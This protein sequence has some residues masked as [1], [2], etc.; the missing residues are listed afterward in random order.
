M[1]PITPVKNILGAI[2]QS[3]VLGRLFQTGS[4]VFVLF[5]TL[6]SAKTNTEYD[7]ILNTFDDSIHF[8]PAPPPGYI[9][10]IADGTY[11]PSVMG[12]KFEFGPNSIASPYFG[13]GSLGVA[14]FVNPDPLH[15]GLYLGVTVM[16]DTTA[17]SITI[18]TG[19]S[20]PKRR[21]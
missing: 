4:T 11:G 19:L 14:N 21:H 16:S 6:M 20:A 10:T 5:V 12:T 2:A 15:S 17:N 1:L 8:Y 9:A 18:W 13:G 7:L 3:S